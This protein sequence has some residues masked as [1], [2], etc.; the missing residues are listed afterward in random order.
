MAADQRLLSAYA[1]SYGQLREA[2]RLVRLGL[3][4][5]DLLDRM[6]VL[7]DQ[8]LA[9]VQTDEIDSSEAVTTRPGGAS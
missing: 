8:R 3:A 1:E 5:P 6:A 2:V 4:S 7:A 9:D